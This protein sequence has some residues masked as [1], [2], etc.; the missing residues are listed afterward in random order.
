MSPALTN[1]SPP[2]HDRATSSRKLP[3][4]QPTTRTRYD[5]REAKVSGSYQFARIASGT[6]GGR[7]RDVAALMR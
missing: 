5:T 7:R 6:G 4:A 1:M 3:T 2:M